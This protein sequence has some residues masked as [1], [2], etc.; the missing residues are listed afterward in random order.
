M[1]DGVGG[2]VWGDAMMGGAGMCWGPAGARILRMN[3]RGMKALDRKGYSL[4]MTFKHLNNL[5]GLRSSH[6]RLIL[7]PVLSA[8]VLSF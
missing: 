8:S 1:R 7:F 5:L 6:I 3:L 2:N 4:L